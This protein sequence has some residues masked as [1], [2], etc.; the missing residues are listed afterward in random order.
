MHVELKSWRIFFVHTV[1]GDIFSCTI[2]AC[3]VCIFACIFTLT[4]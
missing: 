4:A 3:D 2:V 1:S